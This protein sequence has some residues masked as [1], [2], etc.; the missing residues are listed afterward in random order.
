MN[1]GPDAPPNDE[2]WGLVLLWRLAAIYDHQRPK[3]ADGPENGTV[4]PAAGFRGT[5]AR[6]EPWRRVPSRPYFVRLIAGT[7]ERDH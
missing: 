5:T 1:G 3:N 2:L 7:S 6:D 4:S